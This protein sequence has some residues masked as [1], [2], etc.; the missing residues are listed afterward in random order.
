MI[1][2]LLE[3]SRTANRNELL[4]PVNLNDIFSEVKQNIFKLIEES[5]AE[6]I[7]KK[8]LPVLA[9]YRSDI[10]RLLQNLLCNAIKFREKEI[11]PV[12]IVDAEK[13]E[14]EWLFSIQDNGIGIEQGKFEKIFEI[15]TRLHSQQTFEGTGIGLAV[16]KK[17]VEHHGGRIWVESKDR[18]GSIFYF[19]IKI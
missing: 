4:V 11:S 8:E 17:V 18:K 12:I 16:C 6:I 10:S 1:D 9:V 5:N 15:F 13:K 7:V 3:L 19:T 14:Y 2:D